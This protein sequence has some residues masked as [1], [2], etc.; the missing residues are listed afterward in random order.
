MTSTF[1]LWT[2]V[3]DLFAGASG[4]LN[5]ETWGNSN[6]GSGSDPIWSDDYVPS[7]E[8]S[9]GAVTY[10]IVLTTQDWVLT[11]APETVV[12][13]P[14]LVNPF[15]P[16][17][18]LSAPMA[19]STSS[20]GLVS[21]GIAYWNE[22]SGGAYVLDYRTFT[23]QDRSAPS[24]SPNTT[25]GAAKTLFT[26]AA[27]PVN[28]KV[29]WSANNF[30]FSYETAGSA[31]D[32]TDIHFEEFTTA[33]AAIGKAVQVVSGVSDPAYTIG[34]DGSTGNYYEYYAEDSGYYAAEFKTTSGALHLTSAKELISFSHVTEVYAIGSHLLSDGS[35]LQIA[36][37]DV[38]G[39]DVLE[40]YK[41]P[42]NP[43][44]VVSTPI[45]SIDFGAAGS[46]GQ[47]WADAGVYDPADKSNDYT[48]VAYVDDGQVHLELFNASGVEIGSDFVV[49]GITI[50]IVCA[51]WAG[52]SNSTIPTRTGAGVP[53][54]AR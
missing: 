44:A 10:T 35:S 32:T 38:G 49:P 11:T 52:V 23:T 19:F 37:V 54:S 13:T 24:Q 36:E 21:G 22:T 1:N 6:G 41:L 30:L 4:A 2:S 31:A 3:P 48:A 12:A 26:A 34:Y 7:A 9:T 14:R 51:R 29:D 53:R 20:S 39:D 5:G 43:T 50:L 47:K 16:T 40:L 25:L 17:G 8:S 45:D 15:G 33:G 46:T 27:K 42:A 18:N 28:W